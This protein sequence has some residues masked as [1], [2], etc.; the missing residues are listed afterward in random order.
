MR[1]TYSEKDD[2]LYV[3]MDES[4]ILESEEVQPGLIVDFNGNGQVI[5]IEMHGVKARNPLVNP[6][7]LHFE[8]A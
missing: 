6:K 4:A 1:V 2:A 5:G 7:S 3:R 8:V